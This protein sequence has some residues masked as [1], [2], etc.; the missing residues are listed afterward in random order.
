M[1]WIKIESLRLICPAFADELVGGEALKCL[2]TAAKVVGGDEVVEVPAQLL[3]VV[4]VISADC[5]LL[6]RAG[7][8]ARPASRAGRALA[9]DPWVIGLCEAVFDTVFPATHIEHMGDVRG[10]CSI[11]VAWREAE[12]DAPRHRA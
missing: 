5:R 7:S 1:D 2:E 8:S 9:I 6:D 4:V 10:G 12:L 3:V 11:P